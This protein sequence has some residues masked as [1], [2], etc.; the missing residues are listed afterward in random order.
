MLQKYREYSKAIIMQNSN[1]FNFNYIDKISFVRNVPIIDKIT[2]HDELINTAKPTENVNSIQK[3]R[4]MTQ[5]I[6]IAKEKNFRL[7]NLKGI[8]KKMILI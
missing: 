6:H 4:D 5:M 1:I 3:V 7:I 8:Y 2:P